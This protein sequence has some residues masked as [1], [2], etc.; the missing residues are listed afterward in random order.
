VTKVQFTPYVTV[1]IEG[2]GK[3]AR[4]KSVE[5][6][7]SD[8]CQGEI[9]PDGAQGMG[10]TVGGAQGTSAELAACDHIDQVSPAVA[11]AINGGEI[12]GVTT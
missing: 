5:I 8:T 4:V 1:E 12:E 9:G 3:D 11:Y 6:D 2:D 10:G 7:W